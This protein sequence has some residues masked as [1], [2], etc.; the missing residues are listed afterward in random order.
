MRL[1]RVR[2]GIG[3][4]IILD[5]GANGADI[6]VNYSTG[7]EEAQEVKHI[8]HEEYGRKA[9]LITRNTRWKDQVKK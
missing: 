3:R 6:V 5:L 1:P 2:N 7:Q 4:A 9:I 8:I